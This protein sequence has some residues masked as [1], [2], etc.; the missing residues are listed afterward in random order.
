LPKDKIS[1]GNMEKSY[2]HINNKGEHLDVILD[3]IFKSKTNGFYIELG[4]NDGLRQ[5]NTAFF[6]FY[7]GWTGILIEPSVD[8]FLQC[9]E[10]RPN[11]TCLNLACV[12]NTYKDD[13][14]EGD[15]NGHMMSSV[16]GA[17]TNNQNLTRVNVATLE[18]IL[19]TFNAESID[20]LSLDTEGY[21]YEVL[22]GLNLRK[23]RPK[24]ML[25]EI[26]NSQYESL[27]KFLEENNYK[28]IYNLS[29]YNKIDTP[30][31]D[32]THNDYL[33]IDST[34]QLE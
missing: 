2:S 14:I 12:S 3:H 24:Y 16:N 20:F 18:K 11:S 5:S 29:N 26:Y 34:I 6:E 22:C 30:G 19:D 7:R 31:W 27:V 23:Y 1:I 21:E 15:F 25:I 9:R 28:L 4:A 13:F 17:R 33:F 8:A 32:G 10:V